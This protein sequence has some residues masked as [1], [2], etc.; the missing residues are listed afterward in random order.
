MSAYHTPHPGYPA[1][2][3]AHS[4]GGY[5]PQPQQ[6]GHV[7]I[8]P[9]IWLSRALIV[10]VRSVC[11]A[12]RGDGTAVHARS[13][14]ARPAYALCCCCCCCCCFAMSTPVILPPV[15]RPK[16]AT[17]SEESSG[18][19]ISRAVRLLC[20]W[21]LSRPLTRPTFCRFSPIFRTFSGDFNL[22]KLPSR[23]LQTLW[24][25]ENRVLLEEYYIFNVAIPLEVE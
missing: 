7:Q 14:R 19:P 21:R 1:A 12:L 23:R 2:A 24:E 10:E 20:G 18:E 9:P 4:Y 22:Q 5:G 25:W 15:G 13:A 3:V 17:T 11:M 8:T 16:V 6:M